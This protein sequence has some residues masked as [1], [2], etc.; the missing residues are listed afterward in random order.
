MQ[1]QHDLFF[2]LLLL[3]KE[4]VCQLACVLFNDFSEN[5]LAETLH[6]DNFTGS[7]PL[8]LKPSEGK[9]GT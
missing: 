3:F 7:E 9:R 2:P 6:K 4:L 5:T 8:F 1:E